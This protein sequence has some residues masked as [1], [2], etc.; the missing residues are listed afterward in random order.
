MRVAQPFSENI[1]QR[2]T[3]TLEDKG[4]WNGDCLEWTGYKQQGY[5]SMPYKTIF[6]RQVHRISYELSNGPAYGMCVCHS[7]D[8]PKCYNPMHLWL[9]TIGDNI[10]DSANKGRMKFKDYNK[11]LV[12]ERFKGT[13][14][15]NNHRSKISSALVGKIKTKEH[16]DNISKALLARSSR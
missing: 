14:L 4:V 5:G 13:R 15:S 8:N 12:S 9:G 16:S 1:Y 10:K 2:I 6:G 11:L 7:C 3:K